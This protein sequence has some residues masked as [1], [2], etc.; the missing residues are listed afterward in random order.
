MLYLLVSLFFACSTKNWYYISHMSMIESTNNMNERFAYKSMVSVYDSCPPLSRYVTWY[1]CSFCCSGPQ[2]T[3]TQSDP[4]YNCSIPTSL[5][6]YS[7]PGSPIFPACKWQEVGWRP[8]NK[9]TCFMKCSS[10]LS[11][12]PWTMCTQQG[13]R[14]PLKFLGVLAVMVIL[15][16][17]VIL[18]SFQL[19]LC[20]LMY[21]YCTA[22]ALQCM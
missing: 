6:W 14:L 12:H 10:F 21:I 4:F 13:L 20:T 5:T 19:L 22:S 7:V 15:L 18:C 17:Q 3:Q 11:I 9:A 1:L 16:Y 2:C 8:G